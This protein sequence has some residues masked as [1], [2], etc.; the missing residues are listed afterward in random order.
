MKQKESK[1]QKE[2]IDYLKIRGC[3]VFKH[4]NV[5]IYKQSTGKYIPLS[6]G[7]K[8]ISDIIGCMPDGKFIAI[9]VKAEKGKPSENQIEFLEKVKKNKGISILAYSITDVFDKLEAIKN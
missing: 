4:R 7:E 9:E 6:A 3:V 1:L 2:I 8:G 5:G